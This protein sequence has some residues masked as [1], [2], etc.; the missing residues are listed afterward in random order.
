MFELKR[1]FLWAWTGSDCDWSGGC[2]S[3]LMTVN[4]CQTYASCCPESIRK[5]RWSFKW[6]SQPTLVWWT[7]LKEEG[8]SFW[9]QRLALPCCTTADAFSKQVC[10]VQIRISDKN[11]KLNSPPPQPCCLYTPHSVFICWLIS[12]QSSLFVEDNRF[13][14]NV[15]GLFVKI[16]SQLILKPCYILYNV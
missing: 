10:T 14:K 1:S 13:C 6:K 3:W 2:R 8:T 7:T 12:C 4:F 9:H 11:H 15:K 5:F 16:F